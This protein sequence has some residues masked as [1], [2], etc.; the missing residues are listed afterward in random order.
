MP[1]ARVYTGGMYGYQ[2][3]DQEPQGSWREVFAITRIAFEILAKPLAALL[4]ALALF[5]LF[6]WALFTNPVLA[7]IPV[8]IGA[9]GIWYLVRQDRKAVKTLEDELLGPGRRNV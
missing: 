5:I 1:H 6:L 2:P 7:L 4:G 9:A 3:P 8:A